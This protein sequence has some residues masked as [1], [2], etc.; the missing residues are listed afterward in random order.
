[1]KKGIKGVI[2]LIVLLFAFSI[3]IASKS[4][5]KYNSGLGRWIQSKN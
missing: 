1:M 3:A 2:F 5:N 4:S